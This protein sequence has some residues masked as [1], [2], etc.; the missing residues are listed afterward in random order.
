MRLGT[1][2]NIIG[3]QPTYHSPPPLFS[4][5]APALKSCRALGADACAWPLAG[6]LL[7]RSHRAN[8]SPPQRTLFAIASLA[9]VEVLRE[10]VN[11]NDQLTGG[12]MTQS[13]GHA[14]RR[15]SASSV[16]PGG[17]AGISDY[18]CVVGRCSPSRQAGLHSAASNK[19]RTLP[20]CPANARL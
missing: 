3:G 8:N 9:L 15:Y 10:L 6:S 5:L 20:S 7:R 1:S 4:G 18:H 11:I 2:W 16:F 19:T 14:G 12:G 13:S 17:D